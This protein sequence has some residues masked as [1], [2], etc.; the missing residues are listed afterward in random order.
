M[1][2]GTATRPRRAIH[3]MKSPLAT[4]NHDLAVAA[5]L[6]ADTSQ[7]QRDPAPRAAT[8]EEFADYLRTITNR[9]GRPFQPATV[10]TYVYAGRALDAWMSAANIDGDFSMVDTAMLNRF[11]RDYFRQHGQGGTNAQQRNLRHLFNFLQR[12]Q[13]LAHPYNDDL[14]RY[15]EVKHRPATLSGDFIRDLLDVTGGGRARDFEN[16]RDHAII[17][18][19]A[20]E[21]IRRG[22]LLGM[23][24]YAL[25]ADVIKDPVIQLVP[26]KSARAAGQGRPV[27]LAPASARALATYLR[28]RRGHRLAASDAVW[29]G[30]RNRGQLKNTGLRKVLERRAAET[31]YTKVTPHQFRHTFSHQWLDSGG[32]EG[33][34]MRLNGW[35]SRAMVDRYAADVAEQR[36]LEAKRQRGDLY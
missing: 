21:G 36:A 6:R 2:T 34:L 17:R 27:L 8:L 4:R 9:D 5:P 24:M 20:S 31:G 1:T 7:R 33:D 35:K 13:G 18:I 30:T 29:L 28:A 32:S 10:E 26:L 23:M 14:H 15:T 11:F 19:L 22:E 16:A 12:E 25:P 3:P